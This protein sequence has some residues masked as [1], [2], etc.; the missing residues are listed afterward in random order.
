VSFFASVR[1]EPK[2]G[3]AGAFRKELLRVNGPSREEAGCIAIHVYESVREP[4]VFA[5]HSEWIDEAE[6]N[7]HATLPHTVCF[8]DAV[9]PLLTHPVKGWRM[10]RIAGGAGAASSQAGGDPV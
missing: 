10:K 1:F 3:M 6:F 5:V 8:L 9:A 4:L 7:L 2:P